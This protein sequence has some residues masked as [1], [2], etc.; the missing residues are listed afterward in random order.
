VGRRRNGETSGESR[1]IGGCRPLHDTIKDL[2]TGERA[3]GR[4]ISDQK[5]TR[6]RED[7]F[8]LDDAISRRMSKPFFSWE[9]RGDIVD[10]GAN[11]RSGK[12]G[13]ERKGRSNRVA[14]LNEV[15]WAKCRNLSPYRRGGTALALEKKGLV[16]PKG[17]GLVRRNAAQR[18]S[19]GGENKASRICRKKELTPNMR[20]SIF[21]KRARNAGRYWGA[22]RMSY[23]LQKNL[24][25]ALRRRG[26]EGGFVRGK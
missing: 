5:K 10:G 12:D 24:R 15:V 19:K 4:S 9:T 26:K 16:R 7:R 25:Y 11:R 17:G 2:A 18:L 6:R 21:L 3:A 1:A 23:I 8:Q 14:P 22:G 20:P 13:L